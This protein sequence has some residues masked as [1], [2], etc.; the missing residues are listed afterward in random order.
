VVVG[1]DSGAEVSRLPGIGCCVNGLRA[2]LGH[3]N[4]SSRLWKWRSYLNTNEQFASNWLSRVVEKY[5]AREDIDQS[6]AVS[7]TGWYALDLN[8]L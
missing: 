7:I 1:A 6:L 8:A 5:P 3:S 4:R 2:S